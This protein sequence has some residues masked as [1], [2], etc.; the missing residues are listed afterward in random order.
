MQRAQEA[1]ERAAAA[2]ASA[3][4]AQTA[5]GDAQATANEHSASITT[6]EQQIR[7]LQEVQQQ[8]AQQGQHRDAQIRDLQ[9][10]DRVNRGRIGQLSQQIQRMQRDRAVIVTPHKGGP[11]PDWMVD[12]MNKRRQGRGTDIEVFGKEIVALM[13]EAVGT[14]EQQRYSNQFQRAM[15]QLKELAGGPNKALALRSI[16]WPNKKAY[17]GKKQKGEQTSPVWRVVVSAT[18]PGGQLKDLLLDDISWWLRAK[19]LIKQEEPG[20]YMT[21]EE[22]EAAQRDALHVPASRLD[23]YEGMTQAEQEDFWKGCR[24]ASQPSREKKEKELQPRYDRRSTP[25]EEIKCFKCLKTGRMSKDCPED[26]KSCSTCGSKEH[27]WALCPENVCFNCGEKGH[28]SRECQ[29]P[30]KN[31]GSGKG[32]KGSDDGAKGAKGGKKGGKGRGKGRGKG[33]KKGGK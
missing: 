22:I 15:D 12:P 1:L 3:D 19:L 26:K 5:A 2:E 24:A 7:G 6:M 23:E 11:V 4:Q 17:Y 16:G 31:K 20:T 13:Q 32:G 25:P 29:K 10:S 14:N 27:L 30:K 21:E 18:G 8:Q 9:E 33:G 28:L